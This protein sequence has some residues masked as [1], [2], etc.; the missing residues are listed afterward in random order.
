MVPKRLTFLSCLLFSVLA[1]NAADISGGFGLS[2]A[3][4]GSESF[5]KIFAGARG[6]A[7]IPLWDDDPQSSCWIL[8]IDGETITPT[9]SDWVREDRL[10]EKGRILTYSNRVFAMEQSVAVSAEGSHAKAVM[11][12]TNNSTDA[13]DAAPMLLLDTSLGETT[14]LPFRLPDGSY[15]RSETRF[16][17]DGIPAWIKTA[18][19]TS[20]PA[21]TIVFSDKISDDPDSVTAANWL[22]MKQNP[23]AF[24]VEEGRKF[25]FLPFSEGDGAL[26]IAYGGK[27]LQ[28]GG[29]LEVTVVFGL[30]ENVPRPE[31]FNRTVDASIDIGRENVRLREY[32]IRQRL[33]EISSTLS[34]IDALLADEGG[35]NSDAVTN[36]EKQVG[37]QERLR[38]EYENL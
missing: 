8:R 36:I 34:A 13:I 33:R 5:I 7:P 14:G 16:G 27:K 32:T 20:T 15:V 30:D 9:D 19:D 35:M 28:P 4:S 11:R 26:L 2:T 24:A 1:A 18:R 31:E 37:Q 17:G 3:E 38:A 21:L 29:T 25:D 22:R 23:G 12:L 10:T 6:E